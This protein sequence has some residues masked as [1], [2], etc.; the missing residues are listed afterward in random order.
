MK[1]GLILTLFGALIILFAII[2]LAGVVVYIAISLFSF[3][4]GLI[5]SLIRRRKSSRIFTTIMFAF[6]PVRCESCNKFIWFNFFYGVPW[7]YRKAY[8]NF[9]VAYNHCF[10]CHRI[11][12]S[13]K[14]D[15]K[16]HCS[17]DLCEKPLF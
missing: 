7:Y 1:V 15:N 13:N 6:S 4:F 9:R 16:G 8:E 14:P 17:C 3:L 12:K 11:K 5:I 2:A 10:R